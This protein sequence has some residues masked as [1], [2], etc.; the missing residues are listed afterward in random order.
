MVSTNK[1]H[2]SGKGLAAW[3]TALSLGISG[4][5][6]WSASGGGVPAVLVVLGLGGCLLASL[7]WFSIRAP[8]TWRRALLVLMAVLAQWPL[9]AAAILAG[10]A[11]TRIHVIR[12]LH[13]YQT[14]VDRLRSRLGAAPHAKIHVD[15]PHADLAWGEATRQPDGSIVVE[16][17]FSRQPRHGALYF[18][19]GPSQ[20][21]A[22]YGSC[23]EPVG[24]DGNWFLK[25]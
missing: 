11:V 22:S 13:E 2:P 7:L 24:G 23:F 10:R 5:S 6:F 12:S 16:F 9:I 25:C 15:G 17:A 20:P 4:S 19:T 21:P 18:I 3:T 14:S 1:E 8:L